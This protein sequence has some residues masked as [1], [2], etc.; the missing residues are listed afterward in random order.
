MI[1]KI[2]THNGIFHADDAMAVALLHEFLRP[3]I[4]V[5]RT[6]NI[7]P[8]EFT[9][10]GI[11]IVDV[12]GQYN[13]EHNNFDHHH[14]PSLPSACVLVLKELYFRGHIS[15][16]V[17]D[18]L[19][20]PLMEISHIDCNGPADKN[21]FQVNSL[22]KS[23][24]ALID[25]FDLA[26]NVCRL[27]I[28]SCV[29]TAAKAA[30]SRHIWDSGEQVSM[31]IRSCDAFPIHWKRYEEEPFLVYPNEGMFTLISRNSEEFPILST[32]REKFIHA[33]KFLAVFANKKDAIDCANVS[34]YFAVG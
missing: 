5:E 16:V 19:I 20:D 22:I 21:G 7:S 10:P 28:Q 6:R 29:L 14:D 31:F 23:F 2:I 9:N 15:M 24:N 32:G 33:N 3:T 17:Y 11:W 1:F 13:T 30:E 34:S 8:D 26:V 18:E 27:Y 12:G 25:G 4:P